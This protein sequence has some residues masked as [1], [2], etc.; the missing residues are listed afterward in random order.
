MQP[1]PMAETAMPLEPRTRVA[2]R[3]VISS[4]PAA[5]AWRR[6]DRQHRRAGGLTRLEIAMR[7]RRVRELVALVDLDLDGPGRDD[8]EEVVR[9]RKQVGTLGGVGA[10]RRA[11][12]EQR[13]LGVEDAGVERADRSRGLA[14]QRH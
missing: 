3:D 10:E 13:A 12:Q 4:P 14:E 9:R 5:P 6:S 11:G 2:T 8:V 7:L 1:R